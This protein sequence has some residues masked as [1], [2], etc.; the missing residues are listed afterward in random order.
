I[1]ANGPLSVSGNIIFQSNGAI[2]LVNAGNLLGGAV[3]LTT[4]GSD[5]IALV[6]PLATPLAT[7]NVSGNLTITST[8]AIAQSSFVSVVGP[9]LAGYSATEIHLDQL[10]TLSQ[11]HP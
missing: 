1:T 8:G 10:I 7:S 4:T 3:T 9:S 6:N 2:T 11:A 5:N